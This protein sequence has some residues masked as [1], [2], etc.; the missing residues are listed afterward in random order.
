LELAG[1]HGV[2]PEEIEKI[3]VETFYEVTRL[4]NYAPRN[5]IA[6]QF[7][8]P[9]A[10]GVALLYRRIE[11]EDVS[12]ERLQ[13]PEILD[14]ARKVEVI[15]DAEINDQFPAKTIARVT[16]HTARG[17]FQTT[18][19]HAKFHRLTAKIVGEKTCEKLQ[20]AILDLARARDVTSL[21]QLLGF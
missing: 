9:F 16:M 14:L 6:A 5:A 20:A 19:L 15:V 10:L 8:I 3:L 1:R 7:S 11:P 12:E 21:T 17:R 18:D 13:Q 2:R 4:V